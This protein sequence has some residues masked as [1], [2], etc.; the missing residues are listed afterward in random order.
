MC[1]QLGIAAKKAGA[2]EFKGL[3]L[4]SWDFKKNAVLKD[5]ELSGWVVDRAAFDQELLSAA[6]KA[7]AKVHH[8]VTIASLAL[9]DDH[10]AVKLSDGTTL[11]ARILLIS[12]GGTSPTARLAVVG[13]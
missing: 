2:A 3:R 7:G 9:K 5:S 1:G 8:G 13:A 12:D 4:F 10:A 11:A 6:R